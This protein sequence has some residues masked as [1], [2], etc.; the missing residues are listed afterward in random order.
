MCLRFSGTDIHAGG[1][2]CHGEALVIQAA[3]NK[4]PKKFVDSRQLRVRA[5]G[6]ETARP[7][8]TRPPGLQGESGMGPFL[9][10]QRHDGLR[11]Y[12]KLRDADR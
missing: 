10:A 12:S 2:P 11:G 6:L 9:T 3:D 4:P 8:F 7:D 5:H 1:D